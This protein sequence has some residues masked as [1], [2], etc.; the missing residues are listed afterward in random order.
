MPSEVIFLK[1][2]GRFGFYLCAGKDLKNSE[3]VT[4]D[5][6]LPRSGSDC[7]EHESFSQDAL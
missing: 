5:L 3:V 7:V 6:L 2:K 1:R 4:L